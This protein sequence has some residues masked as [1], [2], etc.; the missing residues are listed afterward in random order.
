VAVTLFA[1]GKN[2]SII[3][4]ISPGK[5]KRLGYCIPWLPRV[6]IV[7]D[8]VVSMRYR[9]GNRRLLR[10]GRIIPLM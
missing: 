1:T 4:M 9:S 10:W 8:G 5:S 3:G 2:P 7:T 6:E